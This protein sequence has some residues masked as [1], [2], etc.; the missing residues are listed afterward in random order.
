MRAERDREAVSEKKW[1]AL[2]YCDNRS[3]SFH[4]KNENDFDDGDDDVDM[5]TT[6]TALIK[7]QHSMK[8]TKGKKHKNTHAHRK[9]ICMKNART[10]RAGVILLRNESNVCVCVHMWPHKIYTIWVMCFFYSS[11]SSPVH[12][13]Y[14]SHF[15]INTTSLSLSLFHIHTYFLDIVLYACT[16]D[17]D[18]H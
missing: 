7:K 3:D 5:L 16:R 4:V 10:Q 12:N 9:N 17:I 14:W 15:Y 6:A 18:R 13:K 2:Q 11:F 8:Q 1:Q